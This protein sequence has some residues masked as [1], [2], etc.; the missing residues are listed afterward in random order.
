D[1]IGAL[2]LLRREDDEGL[3]ALL[4]RYGLEARALGEQLLH[5]VVVLHLPVEV[6]YRAVGALVLRVFVQDVLIGLYRALADG[7][8][9]R[10]VDAGLVLLLYGPRDEERRV[11]LRRGE[12]VRGAELRLRLGAVPLAVCAPPRVHA[13]PRS[14][15]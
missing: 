1:V 7:Q 2:P 3:G 11:L 14:Q 5:L 13:V 8:V 15:P 4:S 6:D 12:F 9:L 10:R